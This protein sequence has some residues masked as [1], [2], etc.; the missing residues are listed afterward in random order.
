MNAPMPAGLRPSKQDR[1]PE[2]AITCPVP[3][4]GAQPG[5]RCTTPRGRHLAAGSHPSRLD[6]WLVQQENAA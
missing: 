1:P 6:T 3:G 4:C 2:W 5:A